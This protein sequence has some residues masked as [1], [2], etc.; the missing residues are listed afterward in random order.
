MKDIPL[1]TTENGVGSLV[2][3]EIPHKKLAYVRIHSGGRIPEF[4]QEAVDFCRAAGAERVYAAGSDMLQDRY[5]LHNRILR[6]SKALD[7]RETTDEA[8]WPV[9]EKTLERWLAIY[10]EKMLPVS[11]AAWMTW[12][13]GLAMLH[14]GDGY[15]VHQD[16]KLLG[17][18]MASG[19]EIR[20]VVAA[21]PGKGRDVV[22]ALL[23]ALY[24]DRAVLE[25]SSD[26][27]RAIRLYE[28][29]GFMV[30]EELSRW[31]QIF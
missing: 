26:N 27:L 28:R 17:I 23:H 2:L 6:M 19:E 13:D 22:K 7:D 8:L 25:V 10:N 16:G 20:A 29:L 4:L 18:G 5:T 21:E 24:G 9:Q 15:F 11:N 14:R 31:Y 30:T 1:F 12:E 3:R